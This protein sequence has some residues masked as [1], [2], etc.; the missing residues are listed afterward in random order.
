LR[1]NT[2]ELWDELWG[3]ETTAEEDE[4]SLAREAHS[5]RWRRMEER[6]ITK[7]G[8]L[9]ALRVIEIGA[10][11]GTY[12]ALLARRGARVTLLDFSPNA[13]ARAR[14]FFERNRISAEYVLADAMDLPAELL[15][16]CD[17][18][19]SF[20]LAE[21]FLGADRLRIIQAH[22][23]LLRNGGLTFVS[24]PNRRNL[25]YRLFK[26]ISEMTGS[27]PY[28]EEYPYSRKELSTVMRTLGVSHYGF[29][30]D[31]LLNSLNFFTLIPY[32]SRGRS[33]WKKAFPRNE[34]GR[35]GP[36]REKGTFLDGHLSYALVLYAE[37]LQSPSASRLSPSPPSS[38]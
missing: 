34:A 27:W 23:D 16:A 8:S 20:G 14:R 2:P 6:I 13:L 31:S 36:R 5:I 4:R 1:E 17:I 11:T 32:I 7:F 12:A 19:M 37:K 10:G 38:S 25:P 9:G 21:H 22:F 29:F 24:V 33:L 35:H 15:G 18:S 28:G 26:S 30:G 3:R